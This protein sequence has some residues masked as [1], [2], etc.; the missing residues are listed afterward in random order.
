LDQGVL[1]TADGSLN[2]NFG[3][4]AVTDVYM[5][6]IIEQPLISPKQV[7]AV[8]L[9]DLAVIGHKVGIVFE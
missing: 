3:I 2:G 7:E 9:E 1:G 6:E 5:N 4:N 8:I